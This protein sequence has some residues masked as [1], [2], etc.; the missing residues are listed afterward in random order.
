MKYI[1]DPDFLSQERGQQWRGINSLLEEDLK[2]RGLPP[3]EKL[4][5]RRYFAKKL[6]LP[7]E[8]TGYKTQTGESQGDIK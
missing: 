1:A 3:K 2:F 5:I 4:K 7:A 8:I 6:G